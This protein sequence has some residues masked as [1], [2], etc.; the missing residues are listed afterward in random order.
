MLSHDILLQIHPKYYQCKQLKSDTLFLVNQEKIMTRSTFLIDFNLSNDGKFALPIY[1]TDEP[2]I[3]MLG[4][5]FI[6][7]TKPDLVF[8]NG[9]YQLRF[10]KKQKDLFGFNI[11]KINL[12]PGKTL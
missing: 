8:I 4:L 5:D 2:N 10:H 7:K 1:V 9:R 3:A 12:K 6:Y 11:N